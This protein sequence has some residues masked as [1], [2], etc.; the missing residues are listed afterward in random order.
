MAQ[1]ERNEQVIQEFKRRTNRMKWVF[2]LTGA[3]L[4]IIGVLWYKK[5]GVSVLFP[6][7]C[8]IGIWVGLGVVLSCMIVLYGIGM[9]LDF[10]LRRC[11]ACE[12]YSNSFIQQFCSRCGVP[13]Q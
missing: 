3:G 7:F 11:P 9:V 13:L 12:K 5:Y 1:Q 4:G 2:E 6:N 10:F 8:A